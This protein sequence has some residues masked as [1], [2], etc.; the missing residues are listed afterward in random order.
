MPL[1]NIDLDSGPIAAEPVCSD[2]YEVIAHSID[3]NGL[4]AVGAHVAAGAEV[5][6][7]REAITEA[8]HH[9][10]TEQF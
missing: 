4:H 1:S 3:I 5:T 2:L 6:D 9:C 7:S 10:L 8:I